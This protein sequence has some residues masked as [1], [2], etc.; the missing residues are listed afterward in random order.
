MSISK[1][2]SVKEG[3]DGVMSVLTVGGDRRIDTISESNIWEGRLDRKQ[4]L[5]A[6]GRL[7]LR[8]GIAIEDSR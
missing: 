4:K 8:S 6:F 2:Q 5:D 1:D 7:L 3:K